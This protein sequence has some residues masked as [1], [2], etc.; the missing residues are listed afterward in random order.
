MTSREM[1]AE[2]MQRIGAEVPERETDRAPEVAAVRLQLIVEELLETHMALVAGDLVE[3]ADGFADLKYVVVGCAVAYGLPMDDFFQD[4]VVPPQKPDAAD[5]ASLM[6]AMTPPLK[7]V[8]YALAGRCDLW[9]AL[10]YADVS[11]SIE[12][13]R[14]GLPLREL[15][16]EVHRSN[17]T[18]EPGASIGAAKY[19]PGGGKGPGY[20][21]PDIAGVL[22]AAGLPKL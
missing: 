7:D 17:M 15:F 16:A 21:A 1:A 12:A 11:L 19:G 2:F 10:R 8:A 3:A 14:L 13:A 4:A 18:K 22:R 5:A 20:E 6:L 9:A